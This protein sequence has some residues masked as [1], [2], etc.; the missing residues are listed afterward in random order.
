M[1]YTIIDILDKIIIIEEFISEIY[2]ELGKSEEIG[3]N[4]RTV[5]NIFA[6]EEKRHAETY[7]R[8][9]ER[10]YY[11]NNIEIDF[12]L[13]DKAS[14]VINDFKSKINKPNINN[15]NEILEFMIQIEKENVALIIRIRDIL[16]TSLEKEN[17]LIYKVLDELLV[18]ELKH[19]ENLEQFL[20]R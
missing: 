4:L 12:D 11:E 14:K 10:I 2:V 8:I 7:T 3:V 9:K 19:I 6:L 20:K 15:L 1:S 17:T 18:E 13:Y 5:A 16:I